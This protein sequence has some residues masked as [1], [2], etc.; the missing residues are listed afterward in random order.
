MH[1]NYSFLGFFVV[2]TW[3]IFT[4]SNELFS[5]NSYFTDSKKPLGLVSLEI[6]EIQLSANCCG[7][8]IGPALLVVTTVTEIEMLSSS[9]TH[10]APSETLLSLTQL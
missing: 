10:S 9:W 6:Q 2:L 1:S 3:S 8:H 4:S 5:G 7:A